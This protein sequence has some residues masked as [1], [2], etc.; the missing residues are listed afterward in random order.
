[1]NKVS[2]I[3]GGGGGM[4]IEIARRLAASTKVL[5]AESQPS[6][7][8]IA[9]QELEGLD[10][11]YVQADTTNTEDLRKLAEKAASLGEVANVICA[12]GIS[13]IHNGAERSPEEIIRINA[14]GTLHTNEAFIPLLKEGSVLI[15]ISSMT[16]YNF[17]M[18]DFIEG[19]KEA[20]KGDFSKMI[21]YCEGN[22]SK[23]YSVSKIFIR[24]LSLS[25]IERLSDRGARVISISPGS[26]VTPMTDEVEAAMP[27]LISSF[28]FVVPMKRLGTAAEIGDLVEYLCKPG[29][30]NGADILIDGGFTNSTIYDQLED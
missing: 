25:S 2:V 4:G 1:M 9:R 21:G 22:N 28:N 24:W 7:I 23:A 29:Y 10:I 13:Q 17:E 8:D 14:G 3:T 11:E 27:G 5:I 12:A 30:I 15:N 16:S 6:R 20:L 26:I 19:F 18:A